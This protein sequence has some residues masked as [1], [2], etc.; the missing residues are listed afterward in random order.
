MILEKEFETLPRDEL[1]QLQVERLQSTLYRVYRYV[2][3]YKQSFET[4]GVNIE[5]IK[6]IQDL[7][8]LPFTTKEDLRKSYPYDMFAVPL[9]DILRIHSTSGTTG[10]PIIV[11]YTKNDLR[12][13]TAC[14]ARLLAAAGV[15]EHDVVQI[16]FPFNLFTGGFGFHQGAEQIG[17]SVIP[18]STSPPE[19]Q[20]MIMR[21]FKTTV[22]LCAP[23]YA[24]NIASTLGELQIHAESLNL[25][26]GLF[27]AEPWGENLRRQLEEGL[28][29][30]AL[31]NYGLTEVIGPGVAGECE[32]KNG[33]HINEDHFVAEVIDPKTKAPLPA[34]EEGELVFTTIT[35]EGFPLIRYRTGDISSLIQEPCSCGRTTRRMRRVTGRT[36]DLIFIKG[37]KVFP[38]QIEEILLEA[39]GTAPHYRI[40]LDRQEG[41]DTMEVQVEI[42]ES[43]P[44]FDELK[45]LERL[46]DTITRQIEVVLGVDAKVTLVEP[47]SL[48]RDGGAKAR[49]VIDNRTT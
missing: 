2:S 3:F 29:I 43:Y 22:L 18:S 35:K 40:L 49:R 15:D 45:N 33:L 5:N 34:G 39:E 13:W 7:A 46:R 19:K 17:A 23:S 42:S 26:V 30:A 9:R 41:N 21:D 48:L 12:H 24:V 47:R 6:S 44:A 38:S 20:I 16:A 14:T 11:G 32:H 4:H 10:K 37:Q 27:G 8:Q 31:D 25:K 36:D 28:H 1:E